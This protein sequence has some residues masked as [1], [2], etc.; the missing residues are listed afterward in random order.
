MF[1]YTDA[2]LWVLPLSLFIV[3]V[4][5]V[6]LGIVLKKSSPKTK[7]WVSVVIVTF[8]ILLEI[9]KQVRQVMTGS[10]SFW[11]LPLHYCSLFMFW[12]ALAA[13]GRGRVQE[14]GRSLSV[15]TTVLFLLLFYIDPGSIIGNSSAD[16]FGSFG[17]FHTF[18]YHHLILLF[19]LTLL[20]LHL[21]KPKFKDIFWIVVAFVVYFVV[22][23]SVANATGVNYVNVLYNIVGFLDA[24]RTNLGYGAYLAF[25]FV[26]GTGGNVAAHAVFTLW[27]N[28]VQ[29]R[30][31][32]KEKM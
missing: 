9:E 5:A 3:V 14:I 30:K 27:Y 8:M 20:T 1:Q 24:I 22:V 12:F 15:S 18:I 11:M 2:E 6:I 32:K 16:V 13:Y 23:T 29:S 21:Y 17:N 19:T 4:I 26:A 7:N 31:L 10:Y 25:M 28:R